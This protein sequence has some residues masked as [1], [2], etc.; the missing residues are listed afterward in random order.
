MMNDVDDEVD[1]NDNI[2]TERSR[3]RQLEIRRRVDSND[4]SLRRANVGEVFGY[5]SYIPQSGDWGECGASIGRNTFIEEVCIE[6]SHGDFESFAR[7]FVSNRSVKSLTIYCEAL[8]DGEA[9]GA[10]LPFFMNNSTFKSL[11]IRDSEPTCL[12]ALA[13]ILR[14]FNTLTEFALNDCEEH[15]DD[16]FDENNELYDEYNDSED[17]SAALIEIFDALASHSS[18]T[19]LSIEQE[20][21]EGQQYRKILRNGWES[22]ASLLSITSSSLTVLE[23]EGTMDN[24]GATIL[25]GGLLVN[26]SLKEFALNSTQQMTKNGWDTIFAALKR[27]ACTLEKLKICMS[28]RMEDDVLSSISNA[29]LDNCTLKSLSLRGDLEFIPSATVANSL[30]LIQLLQNPVCALEILHLNSVGLNNDSIISLRNVIANNSRLVE[31][32]LSCNQDV[33]TDGWVNFL[34]F[35]SNAKLEKLHLGYNDNINDEALDVF[36]VALTNNRRLKDLHLCSFP[37][38]TTAGW[39]AFSAVLRN[40]NSLL[41]RLD[42]TPQG[43]IAD[44]ANNI[45]MS[46]ADALT[47]NKRLRKLTI[48]RSTEIYTPF[49]H[50]LCNSSSIMSTY[51]SNHILSELGLDHDGSRRPLPIDLASVLQMNRENNF[52]QA[53]RLKIIKTHFSGSNINTA[54]FTVMELKVL[55]TAISWMG[56]DFGTSEISD[57]LFAFVRSMP[58]LC[59]TKS[60]CKKRKCVN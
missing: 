39:T 32:R 29:L 11:R 24:S 38:V 2:E 8:G 30:D 18:L 50:I 31:L 23:L 4:P 46:F 51:N 14:Q 37:N 7:G 20:A 16:H 6:I 27:S 42:L 9:L 55:P 57:L 33:T 5:S 3:L 41:E 47:N 25:A 12:R 34:T 49:S 28:Q 26:T 35:P 13:S 17:F 21:D 53:A 10:L 56:Q 48:G 54:P 36:R 45:A 59:D 40:P 58:L 44:F 22:L 1:D 15:D 60:R 43:Y 19:K 52:S